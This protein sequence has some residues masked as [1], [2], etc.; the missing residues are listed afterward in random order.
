M[1]LP[2]IFSL[3]FTV[4]AYVVH[5]IDE[6]LLGSSFVEKVREH[7]WP[8]YSWRKF[9][10]FNAGYFAVMVASVVLYDLRGGAWLVLLLAWSIERTCNG[11]WHVGWTVHFREYSPGLVSSILMGT[12]FYFILRYTPSRASDR[13]RNLGTGAADWRRVYCVSGALLSVGEGED[14]V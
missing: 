5:V 13:A 4:A 9:F 10:W 7:W 14:E 2:L 11:L 12:N 6:S 8:Q 1:H 3:W